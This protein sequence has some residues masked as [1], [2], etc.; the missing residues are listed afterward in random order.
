[1]S[2]ETKYRTIVGRQLWWMGQNK[3]FPLDGCD[4]PWETFR[5]D[6]IDYYK[7]Y[8]YQCLCSKDVDCELKKLN[9][10]RFAP[11]ICSEASSIGT[12]KSFINY[13]KNV[14][15]NVYIVVGF[16]LVL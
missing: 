14:K 6:D 13:V 2:V 3:G 10:N 5:K 9:T 12:V 7:D 1:M 15:L 11:C 8:D 16:L 4:C